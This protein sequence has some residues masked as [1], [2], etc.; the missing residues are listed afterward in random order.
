MYIVEWCNIFIS[1]IALKLNFL[2]RRIRKFYTILRDISSGSMM[3]V[4][5]L[6]REVDSHFSPFVSQCTVNILTAI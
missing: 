2:H 3:M 1:E 5:V 6:Y 4:L